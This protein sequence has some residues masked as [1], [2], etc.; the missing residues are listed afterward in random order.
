ML[1]LQAAWTRAENLSPGFHVRDL[2]RSAKDPVV[3]ECP[4]VG[5][6]NKKFGQLLAFITV[7]RLICDTLASHFLFLKKRFE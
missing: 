7:N 3:N 5:S 6:Q 4:H 1:L 2:S